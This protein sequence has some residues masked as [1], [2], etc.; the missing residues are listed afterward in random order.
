[1]NETTITAYGQALKKG[2][3]ISMGTRQWPWLVRAA[4][5]VTGIILPERA[6]F[7]RITGDPT[8]N[9]APIERMDER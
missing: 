8:S 6:A 2:D 4:A 7:W 9:V 5:W 3:I 1:M